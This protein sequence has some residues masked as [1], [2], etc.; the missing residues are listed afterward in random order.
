MYGTA[1]R[2]LFIMLVVTHVILIAIL[3]FLMTTNIGLDR[4]ILGTLLY[5]IAAALALFGISKLKG[6]AGTILISVM[7]LLLFVSLLLP[8]ITCYQFS[9][10]KKCETPGSNCQVGEMESEALFSRKNCV[11]YGYFTLYYFLKI[12]MSKSQVYDLTI[13]EALQ[14][15][16]RQEGSLMKDI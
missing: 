5:T 4:T 8:G 10:S 13:P 14:S 12:I 15:L 6:V 3:R 11:L 9:Q 16:D 1:G 7:N 2:K